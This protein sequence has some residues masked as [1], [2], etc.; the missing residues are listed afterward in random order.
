MTGTIFYKMSGSGNDFIFLDGRASR[1]EIWPAARIRD[2]CR[3]GV[4][5]GADGFV[6]LEPGSGRDRVRFNFFNSDG[7]R[8]DMCGN[9]ALCAARL[10][11]WLELASSQGMILETDA[12]PVKARCVDGPGELAEIVVPTP[13]KPLRVDVPLESGEQEIHLLTVG[14]PHVVVIVEDLGAPELMERGRILRGHPAVGEGGANVNF[15][16]SVGGRWAMRTYERGVEAE[17]LACGTG[18]AA[19][20]TVLRDVHG[21]LEGG[22]LPVRTATGLEVT[23]TGMDVRTEPPRLRGQG[24]MVFRGVLGS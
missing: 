20:A 1:L 8:A 7:H 10:S 13:S 23:I 6:I 9:G 3:R 4:G 12:G 14:V 11:S 24:R 2:L 22:E 16:A 21:D 17:T 18:A 15:A 19:L 5:V